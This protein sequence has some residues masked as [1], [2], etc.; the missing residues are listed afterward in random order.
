MLWFLVLTA[1]LFGLLGQVTESLTLLVA[2]VPLLG[3]DAYLHR[4]TTASSAGLA[5]RLASSARVLRDGQWQDIPSRELV[6][7][8][9]VEVTP[10]EYFPA[11]GLLV[12]GNGLQ[13]DESTLTGRVVAGGQ[14]APR[15][16]FATAC[17][18]VRGALGHRGHT[19][20]DRHGLAAHRLHRQRDA[21]WRD[22]P[23]RHRGQPRRDPAAKGHRRTRHRAA[24]CGGRHVH[25]PRRGQ[26]VARPRVDRCAPE[27]G[28]A[29]RGRAARGVPGRL[30]ILS[31]RRGL[32]SGAQE[33]PGA[34][35]GCG[36]EHR[37]HHLHRVGQDRHDHRRL[38]G[39]GSP[40]PGRRTGRGLGAAGGH[41][42]REA[43]QRRSARPG[44]ARSGGPAAASDKAG[45]LPVH[46]SAA[47][48]DGHLVPGRRR[49]DGLHQGRPR[50]RAGHV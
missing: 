2:M 4:R 48:R 24:R 6:P 28:D 50:D 9:L 15:A 41:V 18:R 26:A 39:A 37:S 25:R 10:G 36:G 43:G 32:P 12:S 49:D 47:P 42:R 5:S 7:G 38:A 31:R 17:Q 29:G 22:R 14:A 46:R 33:G 27:R 20:A 44:P 3:M 1:G 21:L 23:F 11:D 35:R 34:A 8:D 13:V 40:G 19:P 45:R 30:H 16:R